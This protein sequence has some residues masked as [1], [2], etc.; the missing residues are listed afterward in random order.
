M[1]YYF[2]IIL[3]QLSLIAR[4]KAPNKVGQTHM[5][6]HWV[7]SKRVAIML[8]KVVKP[9]VLIQENSVTFL[10]ILARGSKILSKIHGE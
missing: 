4:S 2:Q 8:T 7:G 3:C 1:L 9:V 5:V 6:D 10:V